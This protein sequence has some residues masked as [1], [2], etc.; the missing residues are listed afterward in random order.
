MSLAMVFPSIRIPVT[1]QS[2]QNSSTPYKWGKSI[3]IGFEE[4]E[5]YSTPVVLG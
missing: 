4:A 3:R 5:L 1:L 2:S